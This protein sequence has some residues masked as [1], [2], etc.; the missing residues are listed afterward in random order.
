MLAGLSLLTTLLSP[1]LA[2][3]SPFGQG[4][5][6]ADVPFGSLTSLSISLGGNVTMNLS[7]SGST[8]V[9]HGSHTITVTSND[10]VGYMLYAWS[11]NSTNMVG[12]GSAVIPASANTSPNTL[13]TNTWGYN[14]TSSTTN[15]IGMTTSPVVIKDANG[16][17]K[18]GD[19]TTV[20]YG[21]LTDNA[22]AA[23]TYTIN[24]VYTLVSKN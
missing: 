4:V 13:A 7:L 9:G 19:D 24:V 6:G 22:K 12:P 11:P 16:P 8:Y 20:T 3:A 5:F 14:T 2:H 21:A 23:G 1:A 18:N 17:F 15:F 10:V